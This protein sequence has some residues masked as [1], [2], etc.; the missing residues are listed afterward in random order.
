MRFHKHFSAPCRRVASRLAGDE[1]GFTV[2]DLLVS[3]LIIA[4]L[5]A[6]A[7]PSFL[8]RRSN[9]NDAVAKGM[10][11]TAEQTAINYSL[12]N[13][14]S[15][16]SPAALKTVEPSINTVANGKAVLVNATPTTTGYV[17]TVVSGSADTYN[18]TSV[19]GSLTKTCSVAVGNGNTSTNTGAGCKNGTW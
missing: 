13:G 18:L 11:N 15:T 14:Y 5:A 16:M 9:A 2:I 6:I 1:S 8:A 7:I 17:L 4:I 10:V 12:T 3:C 19:N